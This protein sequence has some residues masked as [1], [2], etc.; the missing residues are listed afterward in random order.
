M[1]WCRALAK[2][3]PT[4]LP[5][6]TGGFWENYWRVVVV[7]GAIV[8]VLGVTVIAL[9]RA[10]RSKREAVHAMERSL[11]T[12]HATLDSV[13]EGVL[14]VD[15]KGRVTDY[16]RQFLE[17]WRVPRELAELKDDAAML[18]SVATQVKDPERFL[19]RVRDLYER[20][21]ESSA[22]EIL[23]FKDGRI[24][25]RDSRPQQS[26]GRIIGRVWCFHDVT[27][28]LRADSE[29]HRLDEQLAQ[30]SKMQALG[31]LAG[32]IAHDFNNILTG[33][34]GYADLAKARLPAAHPIADDLDH[35]LDAANRAREL[36]GQILTFSR[37][38]PP[39]KRILDLEPI[40]RDV[41]KLLRATIPAGIEIRAEM[42]IMAG[43][44]MADPTQMHQA[45]LNLCTNAVHAIG[46]GPG[47][48]VI[49]LEELAIGPQDRRLGLPAGRWAHISVSDT[50][51]GMDPE[52]LR[53]VFE[54]FFTTKPAGE[55]T[56]LGLAVVHGIVET[57]GGVI[58]AESTAGRGTTFHLCLPMVVESLAPRLPAV[59][60]SPGGCGER[61]MVVDDE[62]MVATV[63][64]AYL[65][66]LG[67]QG[68]AY[69]D[70]EMA[71]RELLH[72]HYE[73]LIVDLNMPKISGI[74]L[75]RELRATHPFMPCVL[76]TGFIGPATTETELAALGVTE[77]LAKPFTIQA[78][79]AALHR[80]IGAL[81]GVTTD[82]QA[83]S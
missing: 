21:E 63:S 80:A 55:G 76:I 66:K 41:L 2:V 67:Y 59:A 71:L 34:I 33:V 37:K 50:G 40:I 14:V 60:M 28:R 30:S 39:E 64:R 23:E 24:F 42:E 77:I 16:N 19:K 11:S 82:E 58:T 9:L 29:R 72:G 22:D 13:V 4:T 69:T 25:E 46:P 7:A 78:L 52:T 53:H 56:G 10:L 32:G 18:Q 15:R 54:P 49:G 44:V 75:I 36:I 48:I 61:V 74:A 27:A 31:T 3:G 20:P 12:L 70:P 8:V 35:V 1:G 81:D 26:D 83:S 6:E 5:E 68:I 47:G 38:R 62:E 65:E 57:H 17:M 43:S 79:G 73:A 51:H 45:L